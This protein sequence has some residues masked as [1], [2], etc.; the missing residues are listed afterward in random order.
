MPAMSLKSRL[1]FLLVA[2][3][4]LCG[5][6]FNFVKPSSY[7]RRAHLQALAAARAGQPVVP[8]PELDMVWIPPGEFVMGSP[9]TEPGRGRDE[10]PQHKVRISGFRLQRYL[11]TQGQWE[12]VMGRNPSY[13]KGGGNL[14]VE[15]V[16]W[17]DCI[18]FCNLQS[19]REGRTP[20]YRYQDLGAD[21]Q[22]WPA[23]WKRHPHDAITCDW[24]AD[25]YRLPTEAEW[26]YACRAGTTT[27]TP[28]GPSLSSAQADFN[29]EHPYHHARKGPFLRRTMPVGSYAPNPWGLYDLLGNISQ[30]CWDWYGD[31]P[32]GGQVDPRGAG[33]G[34]GRRVYRGGSWFNYGED[35]RSA[36]RFHDAPQFRLDMLPGGLRLARR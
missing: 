12:A 25:G 9:E 4:L 33:P 7:S 30:W 21:P 32:K 27:A 35:L 18:E 17:Y 15:G 10:S 14:P 28:Y 23:D 19:R 11:V 2:L 26:E 31:Y 3:A 8:I 1:A 24:Q 29:G 16:T 20:C 22:A 6:L 13:F 34:S 5:G 36:N